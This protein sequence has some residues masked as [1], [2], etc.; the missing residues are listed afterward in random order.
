MQF[1]VP[2]PWPLAL[3]AGL[4]IGLARVIK[5]V[6]VRVFW[7]VVLLVA[8]AAAYAGG[9]LYGFTRARMQQLARRLAEWRAARQRLEQAKRDFER[10]EREVDEYCATREPGRIIEGEARRLD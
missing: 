1:Y 4:F 9:F 5:W 10:V 2:I 6:A 3:F 7:P 8:R